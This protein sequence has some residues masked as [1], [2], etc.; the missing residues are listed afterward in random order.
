MEHAKSAAQAQHVAETRCH[1]DGDVQMGAITMDGGQDSP[2]LWQLQT[3]GTRC[4]QKG[5]RDGL[6]TVSGALLAL[7]HGKSLRK[8]AGNAKGGSPKSF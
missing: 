1:K 5:D 2:L 6:T 8:G 4:A 3:E 7:T